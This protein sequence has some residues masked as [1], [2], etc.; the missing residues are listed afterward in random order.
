MTITVKKLGDDFAVILPE[1][2]ARIMKLREGSTL[3]LSVR[4]CDIVLRNRGTRPRRS[5][6][7]IVK[8][9]DPAAYRRHNR[10]LLT[11]QPR[12]KEIW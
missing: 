5:I 11:D 6:R 3:H 12:G 1:T 4:G 8:Q 7:E 2:A 9:I 10:K